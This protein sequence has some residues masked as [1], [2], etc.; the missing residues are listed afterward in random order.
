ML[1]S[2]SV[3]RQARFPPHPSTNCPQLLVSPVRCLLPWD[4]TVCLCIS[5]CICNPT[6]HVLPMSSKYGALDYVF[7]H[8]FVT[9]SLLP[10]WAELI[11]WRVLF[12]LNLPK[13]PSFIFF[14]IVASINYPEKKQSIF[15]GS[16]KYKEGILNHESHITDKILSKS[17]A[18]S[19]HNATGKNGKW[20]Q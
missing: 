3:F 13:C 7:L 1:I 18:K 19:S 2:A 20:I 14:P 8:A 4:F 15:S 16:L 17:I 5:P 9:Y 11:C 6:W 10:G 12:L